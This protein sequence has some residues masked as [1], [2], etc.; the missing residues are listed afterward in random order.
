MPAR[1]VSVRPSP[2]SPLQIQAWTIAN[3]SYSKP[4]GETYRACALALYHEDLEMRILALFTR[5]DTQNAEI[6]AALR[7]EHISPGS[8]GQPPAPTAL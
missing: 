7:P 3:Q 2:P 4:D 5:L 6:D 1:I 8:T